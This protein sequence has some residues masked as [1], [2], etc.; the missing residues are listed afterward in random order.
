M[1]KQT[2]NYQPTGFNIAAVRLLPTDTT[3]AKLIIA[4]GQ[5]DSTVNQFSIRNADS[6]SST[7]ELLLY[8]GT[9]D[10]VLTTVI[11]PANAGTNGIVS[12]FDVLKLEMIY[13][14]SISLKAGWSIRARA[15]TT[16]DAT[17]N[18]TFIIISSDY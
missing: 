17:G 3:I 15:K 8:D 1:P 18:L 6:I 9:N 12:A 4:A 13:N 14:A 7:V 5:N 2:N 16:L 10:F 11:V